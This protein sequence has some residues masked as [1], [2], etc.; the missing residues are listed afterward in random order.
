MWETFKQVKINLPLI[1][2][3]KQIPAYAK[4]LKDLC[5]QK[6]KLKSSLPKK[7]ELTEQV[8]AV[9]S[10]SFPPKL[11]DHGTPLNSI[12]V[13]N[14]YI[15]K[16]LLDLRASINIL[17]SSLVDQ[18]ELGTLKQTDLIT[19][20]VDRR[21]KT[22]RGMLENVIVKVE[23]FYYPVDF[24]VMDIEPSYR[25]IQPTIILG[26]P[27]LATISA[28]IDCRTGAMDISFGNK[29]L[30]INI[31]N[32]L[33]ASITNDCYV[34]DAIN[35]QVQKPATRMLKDDVFECFYADDEDLLEVEEVNVIEKA[36]ASTLDSKMPSWSY[37][38]DPLPHRIDTATKPSF[39]TPHTLE[40]KPLP[41]HL[42][43]VFLGP[44]KSLPVIIASNLSGPPEEA[45]MEVVGKYKAAI[46]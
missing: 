18:Y 30:R 32:S 5:T 2:A 36:V 12:T 14:I 24:I 23:D 16:V 19:Q 33:S 10:G 25:D 38:F 27:F 22:P 35:E 1:D 7:V 17:P 31:F 40:L 4:F 9:L 13:G 20:L 3:I 46:G 44:N 29:K 21:T 41:S 26:R 28:R 8:S 43:Y 37:K 15:K 42:K 45:L 6:R 39:E 11:K 34:I